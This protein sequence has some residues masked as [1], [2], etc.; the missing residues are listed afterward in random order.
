MTDGAHH[1]I[2]IKNGP[3]ENSLV[4][5]SVFIFFLLSFI[6]KSNVAK[7]K[8]GAYHKNSLISFVLEEYVMFSLFLFYSVLKV[9]VTR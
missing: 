7:E 5:L 6:W 8:T 4:K 3:L 2:V 9:N 1:V